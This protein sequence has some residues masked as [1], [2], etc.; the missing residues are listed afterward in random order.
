VLGGATRRSIGDVSELISS[1]SESDLT[2]LTS[3]RGTPQPAQPAQQPQQPQL[4]SQPPS[5][6]SNTS[7]DDR[8]P[9]A[10]VMVPRS[11][12][13][14]TRSDL[15]HT[16][17]GSPMFSP[18]MQGPAPHHIAQRGLDQRSDAPPELVVQT[19]TRG[20]KGGV[21]PRMSRPQPRRAKLVLPST[22][23]P[24]LKQ[25]A[26]D[27]ALHGLVSYAYSDEETLQQAISTADVNCQNMA[28]HSPL[29]LAASAAYFPGK[30]SCCW[31]APDF[32][33]P[34][35]EASNM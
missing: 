14:G 27:S 26:G 21:V 19:M 22:V 32:P 12:S 23:V 11:G 10:L 8:V 28:G 34:R 1:D 15:F 29:H 9:S 7:H 33:A 25:A 16:P 13:N 35:M 18:L 30:N 3:E 31:A 2:P 17:V 4:K 20:G 24:G 6:E 5:R